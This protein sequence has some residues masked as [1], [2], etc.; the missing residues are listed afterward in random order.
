MG[1]SPCARQSSPHERNN[2]V[3]VRKLITN[4][5][6]NDGLHAVQE[7]NTGFAVYERGVPKI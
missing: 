5:Q 1:T 4:L 7:S 3:H 6:H 2:D